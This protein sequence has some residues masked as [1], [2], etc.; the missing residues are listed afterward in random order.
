VG[1]TLIEVLDDYADQLEYVGG[2]LYL[3]GVDQGV[4]KQ[5]RRVGKLDVDDVVQIV[6]ATT[7]IGEST[8][9][10][11]THANA[12]LGSARKDPPM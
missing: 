8:R 10:A 12:W 4:S 7:T 11:I 5:L 1:A 6:P 9:Q 2:R 3:S